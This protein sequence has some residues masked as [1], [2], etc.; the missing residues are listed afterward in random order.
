MRLYKDGV[1]VGSLTKTGN[2][3]VNNLVDVWI[4]DNPSVAGTR[5]WTGIISD[6][7]IYQAA[8]TEIEVNTIKDLYN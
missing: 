3:D 2:I 8:L 4:G 1:E 5:P 7:R 6:V